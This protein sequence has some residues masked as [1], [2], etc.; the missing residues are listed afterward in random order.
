MSPKVQFT[1]EEMAKIALGA[2]ELTSASIHALHI[3]I[4]LILKKL[5]CQN[6]V[7]SLK[8]IESD[9]LV[10]LL[11][12]SK[13]AQLTV[14]DAHLIII[15]HKLKAVTK[16]EKSVEE[17]KSK[18][19]N[20]IQTARKF[21][22]LSQMKYDLKDWEKYK[23]HSESTCAPCGKELN[24]ACFMVSN[25]DFLKKLQRRIAEPMILSFFEFEEEIKCLNEDMNDLILHAVANLEKL[26]LVEGCLQ[27][28]EDLKEKIDQHNLKFLGTMEEVQDI[29]DFKLDKLQIPALK[30]YITINLNRIE[31][32]IAVIQNKVD[33]PKPPGI[34]SSGLRCLSCGEHQVCAEKGVHTVSLLPDAHTARA[35]RM[36]RTCKCSKGDLKL[37]R[38]FGKKVL[39]PDIISHPISKRQTEPKGL[40]STVLIKNCEV[41]CLEDFRLF[42]GIDGNLYHKG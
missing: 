7:V 29:L 19:E 22:H 30:R 41:V 28:V 1:L 20:H 38:V 10:K 2:P 23:V 42:E 9:C 4:E 24:L 3:L 37:N 35:I 5:D 14:D 11:K 6:D 25:I 36:P 12:E 17:V 8:G 27:A 21:S 15:A 13:P 31:A 18:L 34:I 39:N 33:C 26:A 32:R 40:S 16:L